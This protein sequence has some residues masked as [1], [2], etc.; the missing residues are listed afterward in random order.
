MYI[1]DGPQSSA[2]MHD[3]VCIYTVT[4]CRPVHLNGNDSS[5]SVTEEEQLSPFT[6][7]FY[8]SAPTQ[9]CA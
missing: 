2:C 9:L 1:S 6:C 5:V 8:S 4:H 3:I 7:S